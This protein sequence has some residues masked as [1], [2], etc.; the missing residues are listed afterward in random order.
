[1][2]LRAL[3]IFDDAFITFRYAQHFAQGYGL[4]YNLHS[5]VLGTTT[6]LFAILLGVFVRFGIEPPS[7]ARLIA[8]TADLFTAV[9]SYSLLKTAFGRLSATASIAAFASAPY[10]LRI[11]L[12]GMEASLFLATS[13]LVKSAASAGVFAI[14]AVFL[15]SV[16]HTIGV[17]PMTRNIY[18]PLHLWCARHVHP[19]DKIAASDIGAIGYY[20]DAYIY[21][22]A[23]LVWPEVFQYKNV[24]AAILAKRPKFVFANVISGSQEMFDV[25][26]E[27]GRLYEPVARFA[28]SGSKDVVPQPDVFTPGWQQDYVMFERR[29]N[30]PSANTDTPT[31]ALSDSAGIVSLNRMIAPPT[32][33][34][35]TECPRPHAIPIRA[36]APIRRSLLTIVVTAITWSASVAWRIP[37]INPRSATPAGA[38]SLGIVII[39]QS[40]NHASRGKR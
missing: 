25:N 8:V 9:L 36:A 20:S 18:E 30:P 14:G 16:A 29:G 1:L 28:R 15:T 24:Y 40:L 11:S 13:L 17:A 38:A 26:S 10:I 34:T 6:P 4:V 27:L 19:T 23:G 33:N 5:R 21:D 12:G 22:L 39:E 31:S 2:A 32:R 37:R 35:V 3:P 7:A